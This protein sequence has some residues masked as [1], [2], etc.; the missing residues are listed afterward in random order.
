MGVPAG[1]LGRPLNWVD[2]V[3]FRQAPMPPTDEIIKDQLDGKIHWAQ[4]AFAP[5]P[6]FQPYILVKEGQIRIPIINLSDNE[7]FR[8]VIAWLKERYKL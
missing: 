5:M 1:G 7:I 8:N 3:A 4:L 2:G 6:K